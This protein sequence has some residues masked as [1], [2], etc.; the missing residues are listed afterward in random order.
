M[1]GGWLFQ[2]MVYKVGDKVYMRAETKNGE[3]HALKVTKIENDNIT[4][5]GP[6]DQTRVVKERELTD[7]APTAA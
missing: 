7:E 4:V 1:S 3:A 2:I 5:T 6:N